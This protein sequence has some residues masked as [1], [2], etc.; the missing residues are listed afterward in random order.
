[1]VKDNLKGLPIEELEEKFQAL[2]HPRFR[3]RQI[4]RWIY[5]EKQ[6]D[7]EQMTDLGKALRKTLAES[8]ELPK[9]E[10]AER[11]ESADGTVKYLVRLPDGEKVESVFIPTEGRNT[12]C[13]STQVGCKMACAFCATGYQKFT[14]D[15]KAWEIVDQLLSLDHPAQ[16][17]NIVMMGMGEPF[18]NYDEVIRALRIFQDPSGPQIGKRHITVSTVGLTPKIQNFFDANLGKLAISLHGTTEEQRASIMPVNRKFPLS[19][20]LEVC[21]GIKFKTRDRITWEYILIGGIND[22]DED[23]HRLAKLLRGIPSKINLLMYNENSFVS[24]KRPPEERVLT[25]QSILLEAGY[26]ATYRRSRGR[27][28]AAACGQLHH[29]SEARL[30]RE[31]QRRQAAIG[32]LAVSAPLG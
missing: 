15:L 10:M 1:M 18:D 24:F 21:R 16:V 23:A 2:G 9:L 31:Q 20:L 29:E 30:R 27:D 14:R 13:V 22:S 12:L 11:H 17:T 5:Q 8:F 3:A 28:I 19:Q 32:P 7:F 6:H 25:F 26:T 4:F